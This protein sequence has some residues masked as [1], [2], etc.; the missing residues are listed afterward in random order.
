M[1]ILTQIISHTVWLPA[2]LIFLLLWFTA[3][4]DNKKHCNVFGPKMDSQ[5][6]VPTHQ[7]DCNW[8]SLF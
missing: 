1:V 5:T 3:S 7:T 2:S 4:G 8:F 6:R